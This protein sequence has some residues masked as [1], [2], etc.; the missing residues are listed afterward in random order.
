MEGSLDKVC[1]DNLRPIVGLWK[2]NGVIDQ[3][4]NVIPKKD[5]PKNISDLVQRNEL[6]RVVETVNPCVLAASYV[7]AGVTGNERMSPSFFLLWS[8]RK[9]CV[10]LK[11]DGEFNR[12]ASY[13]LQAHEA[14]PQHGAPNECIWLSQRKGDQPHKIRWILQDE[15]HHPASNS[16]VVCSKLPAC[17][18]NWC[19]PKLRCCECGNS[20]CVKTDSKEHVF[21][22]IS[23]P[24]KTLSELQKACKTTRT[25]EKINAFNAFASYHAHYIPF[26]HRLKRGKRK[27]GKRS[28]TQIKVSY[29]H[30]HPAARHLYLQPQKKV[31]KLRLTIPRHTL[32]ARV[33]SATEIQ[34]H[35]VFIEELDCYMPKLLYP[36]ETQESSN[37]TPCTR[38]VTSSSPKTPQARGV[39]RRKLSDDVRTNMSSSIASFTKTADCNQLQQILDVPSPLHVVAAAANSENR[40]RDKEKRIIELEG[41]MTQMGFGIESLQRKVAQQRKKIDAITVEKEILAQQ[42][43]E[44]T[45]CAN[46]YRLFF[47]EGFH[48]QG[49]VNTVKYY[50]GLTDSFPD[51]LPLMQGFLA[52]YEIQEDHSENIR[53]K[54]LTKFE[55]C[56][57]AKSFV[58]SVCILFAP[59]WITWF[60]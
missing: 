57:L 4:M 25:R 37:S 31:F 16:V 24:K 14:R 32:E 10:V 8:K 53:S 9:E 26:K 29:L 2:V 45:K 42:N 51:L 1:N 12:P 7:R 55:Q 27:N 36:L 18:R 3:H 35:F 20:N 21:L 52:K 38:A 6:I 22:H 28:R 44:L 30:A 13:V 49:G 41:E 48:V 54:P 43:E 50:F 19:R 15:H 5:L 40:L 23:K 60:A 46:K 58:E 39:K 11:A 34:R 59:L 17:I 47:T 33:T 56:L